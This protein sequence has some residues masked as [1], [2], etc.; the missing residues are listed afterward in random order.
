MTTSP[1]FGM[2]LLTPTGTDKTQ[3]VNE[4][5]LILEALA[6]LTVQSRVVADPSTLTPVDGQAWLVAAAAVGAWSGRVNELALWFGGWVFTAPVAGIRGLV[7]DE[8][9]AIRYSG[10]AWV[11]DVPPLNL[12]DVADADLSTAGPSTDQFA[13]VWN[14]ATSQYILAEVAGA[15]PALG[16]LTDVD[17]ADAGAPT[18]GFALTWDNASTTFKLA[19]VAGGGGGAVTYTPASKWFGA[20]KSTITFV[21][22]TINTHLQVTGFGAA[23]PDP[24]GF[25]ATNSF[26]IPA[27]VTK[28]RV[29]AFVNYVSGTFNNNQFTIHK[30]GVAATIPNG[31]ARIE[32]SPDNFSNGGEH[33]DTGVIE[34]IAGDTF[35]LYTY[36][37]STAVTWGAWIEIEAIEHTLGS[38]GIPDVGSGDAG[39]ALVVNAAETGYE[40]ASNFVL[41]PAGAIG[42]DYSLL[43]TDLNGGVYQEVNSASPVVLTVPA[44]LASG[45]PATFERVGAGAV[46]FAAGAGVTINSNGG[47]LSIGNQFSAATLV[48]KGGDVYTLVGDLA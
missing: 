39:K 6:H 4:A 10:T 1:R 41:N 45:K 26:V 47:L 2:T 33:A 11:T 27:G 23:A 29:S 15:A 40:L 32:I 30:N 16:G 35:E 19:A 43:S 46:T 9:V 28:V 17:V 25:D 13:V 31:Q 24:Y 3:Q 48:P 38:S 21:V 20:R 37:S 44:G 8:T 34:V 5:L 22:P 42:V 18:D 36:C 7:L 12:G 14:D